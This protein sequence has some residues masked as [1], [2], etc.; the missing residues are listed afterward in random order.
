MVNRLSPSN[1][2]FLAALNRI[3]DRAERATR[4]IATGYRI[5][6]ASDAPDDISILL[7]ARV[8]VERTDQIRTNLG[9]V[10]TEVDTAEEMLRS[11][12]SI[13]ERARVLGAQ[14]ASETQTAES[15]AAAAE[16]VTGILR[17]LVS[18]AGTSVDG[19]YIFSGDADQRPPYAWD[20]SQPYPVSGY[21]GGAATR[22]AQ[23]PSGLAF[24]VS[25]SGDAIF[26]A[27]GTS[28]FQA[29][30]QLSSALSANDTAAIEAA[31]AAVTA[32]GVHLNRQLAFYGSVQGQVN[33]AIADASRMKLRLETEIS[34]LQEADLTESILELNQARFHQQ[35]ALE[36]RAKLPQTSLFDFLR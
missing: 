28:V 32:A 16:E 2:S 23:H 17:Q 36:A 6:A 15:R 30:F 19:R 4:Q 33:S 31:L 22:L 10:K 14:G 21:Q 27:A 29:V 3:A 25:R 11:A 12:V 9:R 26:D 35:A 13:M 18:I 1:E 5:T 34:R 24:G 20:D 7:Q 8:E